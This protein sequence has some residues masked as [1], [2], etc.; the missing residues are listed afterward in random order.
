MKMLEAGGL[1]VVVDN[2]RRAD[3]D[4]PLGYY[5]FEKVKQIKEDSSWLEDTEGKVFKIVSML[6]Y[7]LPPDRRYKVIFMKRKLAEVLASQRKMLERKG[8]ARD[9]DDD[10]E[11]GMFFE[12]HLD[13]IRKWLGGRN[14]AEVLYMSY[15]DLLENPFENIKAVKQFLEA[16]LDVE[17]MLG[18]IDKSLYRQRK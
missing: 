7:D 11:T 16:E 13:E 1:Q 17:K 5:E 3:A 15:N 9:L 6:L 4:N 12:R 18:V 10:E 14:N 8:L 2:I